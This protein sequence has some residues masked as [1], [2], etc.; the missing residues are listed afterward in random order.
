M[1]N[2][3]IPNNSFSYFPVSVSTPQSTTPRLGAPGGWCPSSSSDVSIY[4]KVSLRIAH[5][6]CAIGT[7]GHS[8]GIGY[9]TE[10]RV[11]LAISGSEDY[12]RE[13]GTIKVSTNEK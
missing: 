6:L 3:A 12:Y 1:E 7:Q 5:I 9:V 8:A 2:K 4:F 11:K 10:Y 13:K